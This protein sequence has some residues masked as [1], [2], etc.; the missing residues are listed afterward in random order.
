MPE[1]KTTKKNHR[2]AGS[3]KQEK[4]T[5]TTAK[6]DQAKSLKKATKKV[7]KPVVKEAED[8]PV[9]EKEGY[10]A[11]VGKRKTAIA[12]VRIL[13]KKAVGIQITVNNKD[14]TE[15]F[16]YFE[17]QEIITKPLKVAGRANIAISVKVH[18]GGVRGQ[19][20]GV[21]HGI[22]R[23]L[24]K[25]DE[26]LRPNLKAEGFLTRDDRKKERK[27]PGLKKARRAPQWSKR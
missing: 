19:V 17:W 10:I 14:Y 5:V 8:K 24:L 20:E 27:K 11:T 12:R 26:T 22:S 3:R 6:R 2:Q 18:G 1:T 21:R 9:G 13:D 23:A 16:P 4:P 7:A 15:Y 25:G